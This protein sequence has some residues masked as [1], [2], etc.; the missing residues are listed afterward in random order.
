MRNGYWVAVTPFGYTNLNKKEKAKNH[1][2]V[3]NR[4]GKLLKMAFTLKAEG[5]L[6]NKMIVK[7]IQRLGSAITYKNFNAIISN[8]FYCGYITHSLIPGEIFKGQHPPLISKELFIR[9]NSVKNESSR[10]GTNKVYEVNELPL[11]TFARDEATMSPLTG[12][13]QKGI[14]Y[15]KARHDGAKANV[16]AA[17]LNKLFIKQLKQYEID[18]TY[19]ESLKGKLFAI[20]QGKLKDQLNDQNFIRKQITELNSKINRLE[21]KYVNDEI[22]RDMFQKFISKYKAEKQELEQKLDDRALNSSNLEKIISKGLKIAGNLSE[23]WASSDF[24]DKRQLQKLVFPEGIL[25]NK[26]E[27]RVQ[28]PRVNSLFLPIPMLTR[29][30]G[31]NKNGFLNKESQESHLVTPSGFK[32]ETF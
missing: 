16:N 29:V 24:A 11:K 9:A 5:K 28:T 27:D 1:K 26:S 31:D 10:L 2:Y 17:H 25:Y 22:D 30:S 7:K 23:L 3:I 6:T 21:E 19:I 20:I 4:D 32:P 18:K 15:Y 13:K 12:F 14:Y 8:P